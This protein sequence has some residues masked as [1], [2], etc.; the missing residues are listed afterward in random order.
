MLG[1]GG[2][3]EGNQGENLRMG[4]ELTNQNC[5]EGKKKKKRNVRIYKNIILTLRYE[6]QLK[7]LI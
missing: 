2:R 4:V 7:K 1:I 6:K 5:A 3:N